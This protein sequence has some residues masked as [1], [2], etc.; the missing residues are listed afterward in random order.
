MYAFFLHVKCKQSFS[1]NDIGKECELG[2][3]GNYVDFY[4]KILACF[5]QLLLSGYSR[6]G[7][8]GVPTIRGTLQL[9][10]SGWVTLEHLQYSTRRNP[11]ILS[12]TFD[13]G[14]KN[15]KTIMFWLRIEQ[16]FYEGMPLLS[17]FGDN[18]E[19]LRLSLRKSVTDLRIMTCSGYAS[20]IWRILIG[21][22]GFISTWVTHSHLIT[23]IYK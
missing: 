1:R 8:A 6:I 22:I 11:E 9:P 4:L 5:W 19:I 12:Y 18:K 23:L 15:L 13:R 10:S 21:M 20:L 2:S 16:P 17:T 7:V 3:R 14:Q